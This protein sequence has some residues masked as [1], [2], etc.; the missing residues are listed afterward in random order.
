MKF[1]EPL[2][3]IL[4]II[5]AASAIYLTLYANG[6]YSG[7]S[8]I[9]ATS[10]GSEAVSEAARPV[11]IEI[12]N[13]L[14]RHGVQYDDA[15][16]KELY[17]SLRTYF[18]EA[19][20]NAGT[21][22]SIDEADFVDAMSEN[23]IYFEYL[24]DI[25]VSALAVWLDT[26]SVDCSARRFLIT[27]SSLYFWG[28]NGCYRCDTSVSLSLAKLDSYR[29]NNA[30]FAYE[31][32][33]EH[34]VY[35]DADP[36][37]MITGSVS[38][39]KVSSSN[40]LDNTDTKKTIFLALGFNPYYDYYPDGDAKVYSG[41]DCSLRAYSDHLVYTAE[42]DSGARFTVA[43]SG[44]EPT[45]AEIINTSYSLVSKC[46]EAYE[47]S[48]SLFLDSISSQ[49]EEYS[50]TF[51][52]SINGMSVTG[53]NPA[54]TVIISSGYISKLSLYPR[55][56]SNTDDSTYV[57]PALQAAALGVSALELEY[58]DTGD[59]YLSAGWRK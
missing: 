14:G 33:D 59:S 12:N 19:L 46:L 40:P 1:K 8:E 13:S 38:P 5:L 28:T 26:K 39:V 23:G 31:L 45:Q 35:A 48:A 17:K 50:I 3:T 10:A 34:P 56:Y 37:S 57:L 42:G 29:P 16:V 22:K 25:P 2:K 43:Y 53:E 55:C 32:A 7:G 18:S 54:A 24:S 44:S 47:G 11:R 15:A 51:R 9:Y 58:A 36:L 52:Y 27:E 6:L 20:V 30:Y 4:I 41:T 49:D 21:L